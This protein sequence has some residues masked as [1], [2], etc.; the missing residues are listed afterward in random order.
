[1]KRR[2]IP[3]GS[4]EKTARLGEGESEISG[5]KALRDQNLIL[6]CLFLLKFK[7]EWKMEARKGR[8]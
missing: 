2:S 6:S 8:C 4:V 7:T 1:V 5:V 3:V